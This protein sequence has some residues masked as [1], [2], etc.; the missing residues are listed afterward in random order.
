MRDQLSAPPFR[1]CI[2]SKY[3][4]SKSVAGLNFSSNSVSFKRVILFTRWSLYWPIYLYSPLSSITAP[5]Y[6]SGYSLDLLKLVPFAF[7][8]L[9]TAC[10]ENNSLSPSSN[11]FRT[12]LLSSPRFPFSG[13]FL[14]PPASCRLLFVGLSLRTLSFRFAFWFC[15]LFWSQSAEFIK[16]HVITVQ[17]RL[18]GI[19]NA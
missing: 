4:F 17:P 16:K 6:L 1:N 15:S 13:R 19:S 8:P 12:L 9:D 7:L 11:L 5:Q 18:R 3:F 10:H 14:L 2:C